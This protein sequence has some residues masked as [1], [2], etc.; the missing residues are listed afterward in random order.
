M[1]ARGLVPSSEVLSFD[2][3]IPPKEIMKELQLAEG[4][5]VYLITRIRNADNIPM[6]LERTYIP[7]SLFP[8]LEEQQLVQSLYQII[9][10][11]YGTKISHADQHIEARLVSNSDRK[12]LQLAEN[13]VVLV[14]QRKSYI[15]DQR[16]VEFVRSM[17][18][19]DR[20]KF[21]NRIERRSL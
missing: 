1:L 12:F 8:N 14:M 4:E 17:Y 9:E 6:A 13:S 18:R 7:V 16:P 3:L 11:H 15:L 20:Y 19:A 21:H 2:V 5:K 10:Q